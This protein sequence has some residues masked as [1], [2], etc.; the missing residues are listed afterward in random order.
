MKFFLRNKIFLIVIFLACILAIFAY[1]SENKNND[2]NISDTKK[3]TQDQEE[4]SNWR[5]VADKDNKNG[6]V[7]KDEG[8]ETKL[9]VT[10]SGRVYVAFQDEANENRARIRTYDGKFWQ[11]LADENNPDGLISGQKGGDPSLEVLGDEVYVAFMD[12]ENGNRA[13]VKRWSNGSWN[14]VG[15]DSGF[16]SPQRGHEPVLAWDKS[17]K[18]LYASFAE[19]PEEDRECESLCRI[20]VKRW[21][22]SNW[23]TVGDSEFITEDFSTEVELAASSL[24]DSMYVIFE[25]INERGKKIRAMEWNGLEWKN[26]SSEND[27]TGIVSDISAIK[28]SLAIDGNDNLYVSFAGEGE[29]G[30][31]AK[32]WN[33]KE[34]QSIGDEPVCSGKCTESSIDVDK[35]GKIYLA[36]SG[37]EENVNHKK[38]VGKSY[39]IVKS[40]M[41]RLKVVHY[42]GQ[43]WSPLAD[44]KYADGYV[45]EGNGKAD[46]ELDVSGNNLFISFTDKANRNSAR[47]VKYSI[48]EK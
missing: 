30:I 19:G 48:I 31:Y 4:K 22:G 42:D 6:V 32:K 24:D 47:V 41:W 5:G 44:G 38:K 10:E 17:G 26:I 20:K 27:S 25:N 46:P 43:K 39:D 12:S 33:G 16:I 45:S 34:W 7:S 14:D 15:P 23:E 29:N 37:F 40:D 2:S 9:V 13:R 8:T 3:E 11:D 18:F 36:F 21:D 1:Q 28:P 35:E